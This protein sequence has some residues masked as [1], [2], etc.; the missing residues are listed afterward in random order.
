MFVNR[1]N[2]YILYFIFLFLP[3][4]YL[5]FLF[6][7]Y[8]SP[9]FILFVALSF[10]IAI[11]KNLIWKKNILTTLIII[12]GGIVLVSDLLGIN[13]RNSILGSGYRLQGFITLC[14]GILLYLSVNKVKSADFIKK[15]KTVILA[16]AFLICLFSI[17]QGIS[18]YL[19]HDFTIPNYQGRI[20]GTIGNPNSLGGYLAVVLSLLLFGKY[21]G[22]K[23]IIFG[24]MILSVIF[25]TQSRGAILA[26]ALSTLVYAVLYIRKLA[27][28][29]K[30]LA[31]VVGI[32]FL[33]FI[34][35][36]NRN[37]IWDNRGL[38]WN[39]GVQAVINRPILGYG[40]ENFDLIFPKER[41]M[42]VDSAHNIFLE[43]AVSSGLLGL[44][45]FLS[46]V[47]FALKKGDLSI[48]MS[49]L[50]FLISA[51]F[52]PLSISQIALFWLLLGIIP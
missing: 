24:L 22:Y 33:I 21:A 38:I 35:Q 16:S 3:L 23:K 40:Q 42:L 5:P 4:V 32:I 19:L 37:S 20:V 9:K 30:I 49:L 47:V 18:F 17:W 2:N 52:N 29:K 28:W 41:K 11:P 14:S 48:R 36:I 45:T 46:I 8:E 34:A 12:Y 43:T 50:A 1:V 39:E 27:V 6:N 15:T 51:Q 13:V 25:L 31:V 26:A 7:P 44:V 10:L